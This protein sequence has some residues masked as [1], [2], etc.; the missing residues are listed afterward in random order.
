[1]WFDSAKK[2]VLKYEH[3]LI[4]ISCETMKCKARLMTYRG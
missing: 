3:Q 1:M 2:G 4:F